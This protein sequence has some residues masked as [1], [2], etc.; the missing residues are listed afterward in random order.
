[1]TPTS[2][3]VPPTSERTEAPTGSS[4]TPPS[5]PPRLPHEPPI[6]LEA[7]PG[8]GGRVGTEPEDFRVDEI[9]LYD[10]SGEGAHTYVHVRKR[11]WTTR[12]MI[13]SLADAA[14]VSD[15]DVGSAGMKDRW[16]VTSQW[17]SFP[18][19]ASDPATWKLEEGL[20]VLEVTRHGNKLRTGHLRANRFSI[21]LQ[22]CEA[23]AFEHAQAIVEAINEEGLPNYFGPQRFGNSGMNV[24]R[25]LRWIGGQTRGPRKAHIAKFNASVLQSEVFNRYITARRELGLDRLFLGETVRL[26]GSG[27]IFTVSDPTEDAPRLAAGDIVLTAPMVGPK[28]RITEGPLVEL[29]R[30]AIEESGLDETILDRL[31]RFGKG[32][33]RD[34]VIFPEGLSVE[35]ENDGRLV[36]SFVL[37]SGC[38]ATQL[39]REFTRG[40]WLE[41][42]AR[43]DA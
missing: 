7:L 35:G 37:P 11:D 31:S 2:D 38:Y 13:R 17:L 4:A 1:V 15:R 18:E 16:A 12:D 3:G 24:E 43:L 5:T 33:R 28:A 14:G 34:I 41:P 9:P 25:A 10:F 8:T 23:D 29:E 26:N 32:T 21:R 39:A 30:A 22:D 19:T 6:A 36:L 27:S 20:E 42:R 40:T